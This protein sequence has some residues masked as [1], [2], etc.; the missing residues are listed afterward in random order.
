MVFDVHSLIL[1][2]LALSLL[3]AGVLALVGR[4]VGHLQGVRHWAWANLCY[5][6]GLAPAFSPL[7]SSLWGFVIAAPFLTAAAGLQIAGIQAF[8][9][10]RPDWRI[11]A[12]LAL[13]A[14]LLNLL[15]CLVFYNQTLR[16]VS[17]T[18]LLG[19]AYA[20]CARLL[21]VRVAQPMRTAYWLTGGAFALLALMAAVRLVVVLATRPVFG[22]LMT[23]EPVNL[24]TFLTFSVMVVLVTFGFVLM[25]NFRL[26]SDLQL[27]A[28]H[29][30]LTGALN[31]RGFEE[32]GRQVYAHF[33][34]SGGRMA[35]LL[36]DIDHFKSVNDRYGHPVGD[37]VLRELTGIAHQ[38][39]RAEDCFARYGGE[40][41]C[42]LLPGAD[43]A[44]AKASAE[45]LRQLFAA[46][47]VPCGKGEGVRC[48]V[49][50][51]IADT[52]HG[53]CGFES[54]IAAADRA[55]YQAKQSGRDRV[56][57][58][59]ELADAALPEPR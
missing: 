10:R 4:H 48:T 41:F 50:I 56:V 49:S 17:N 9:G 12:A 21:L 6:I 13:A 25:L 24:L 8:Q 30:A 52:R 37:A 51:G 53:G 15:F 29:D 45:R 18:F 43:E 35:L 44:L 32:I 46:T 59:S 55:L 7:G 26:A 57:C 28:T 33:Q 38:A 20:V 27:L 16:I 47:A 11:P 19:G 42:V 58:V 36:L 5:S 1:V 3:L 22:Y 54:L 23:P 2:A 14:F 39:I 31:R 34:R 40:E